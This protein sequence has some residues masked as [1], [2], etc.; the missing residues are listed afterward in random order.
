MS[1]LNTINQSDCFIENSATFGDSFLANWNPI[2]FDFQILLFLLILIGIWG[3]YVYQVNFK[4]Y[5]MRK[6]QF[7]IFCTSTIFISST[8]SV[9]R[10]LYFHSHT[11]TSVLR[12]I[13]QICTSY[14]SKSIG[15]CT[16]LV[17]VKSVVEVH[18][19]SKIRKWSK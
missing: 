11:L 3:Q 6:H 5:N 4:F 17:E 8:F 18:K 9:L 1:I 2:F 15:R 13:S 19:R 16:V 12:H 7:D 10:P 14:W